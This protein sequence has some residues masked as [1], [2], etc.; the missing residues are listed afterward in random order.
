M[1]NETE[2]A[3]Q[4]YNYIYDKVEEIVKERIAKLKISNE[5]ITSDKD[6]SE[7]KYHFGD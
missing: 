1:Y 5:G 2:D 7:V 3:E 6:I 4:Y